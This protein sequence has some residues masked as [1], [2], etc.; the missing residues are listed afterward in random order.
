MSAEAEENKGYVKF[1][2]ILTCHLRLT[3]Y[4]ECES[5]ITLIDCE[6]RLIECWQYV[7]DISY[8]KVLK[9]DKL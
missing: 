4:S 5:N 1:I 3:S 9:A 7:C 6:I 8:S 2:M